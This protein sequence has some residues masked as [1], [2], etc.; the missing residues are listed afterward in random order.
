MLTM[1]NPASV[2]KSPAY[3]QGVLATDVKRMLFISGQVGVRADGSVPDGIGEQAKQAIANLNAVLADAGMDGSHI[4][5]MTIYLT[6]ESDM[7]GFV[8]AATGTLPNP[9][10]ATTLL[11]VKALGA[12]PLKIEIEAVAV[13]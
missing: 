10:P 2:P 5:K 12:P 13:G 7:G 4:A 3:S 8:Q 9:P 11:F 6:D 1:I